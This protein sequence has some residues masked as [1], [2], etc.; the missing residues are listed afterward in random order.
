MGTGGGFFGTGPP[1]TTAGPSTFKGF[2]F[3]FARLIRFYPPHTRTQAQYTSRL[4]VKGQTKTIVTTLNAPLLEPHMHTHWHNRTLA[5]NTC[6]RCTVTN[7]G[8]RM[9]LPTGQDNTHA[10]KVSRKL[11]KGRPRGAHCTQILQLQDAQG[12]GR[13]GGLGQCIHTRLPHLIVTES[14]T[15]EGLVRANSPRDGA[16]ASIP[17]LVVIQT[18]RL[19]AGE[20]GQGGAQLHAH[21]RRNAVAAKVNVHQQAGVIPPTRGQYTRARP[22]EVRDARSRTRPRMETSTSAGTRA[23]SQHLHQ[24]GELRGLHFVLVQAD[25][26]R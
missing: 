23:N 25:C 9:P 1:P 19:E 14:Q 17:E 4:G 6:C 24:E 10:Q 26:F 21:V 2:V 3:T 12:L 20:V 8:S 7:V 5:R 11:R 16:H 18:Q 15:A 22:I 13:Q